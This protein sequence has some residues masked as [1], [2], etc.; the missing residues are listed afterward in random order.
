LRRHPDT[1]A[2]VVWAPVPLGGTMVLGA[3]LDHLHPIPL[4]APAVAHSLGVAFF[5]LALVLAGYAQA[6][7]RRAG[8][9]N[10][11]DLP[12]RA[13]ATDGPYHWTRNPLYVADLVVYLGVCFL[14]NGLAPLLLF[15]PL[16]GLLQWSA[17]L[18]EERYLAAKFGDAYRE[19][20]TRVRR[21]L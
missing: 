14:V 20:R 4:L 2:I 3:L 7:L 5:V 12:T 19:Y 21:W 11:L 8:T 16:V 10:R 18:P 17:V 6:A 9:S 1:P 13:L 15:L